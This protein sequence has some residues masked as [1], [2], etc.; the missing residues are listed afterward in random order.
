MVRAK[1]KPVIDPEREA[2]V[3]SLLEQFREKCKFVLRNFAKRK[4]FLHMFVH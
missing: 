1:K 2:E 3:R 4:R